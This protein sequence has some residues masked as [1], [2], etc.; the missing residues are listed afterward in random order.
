VRVLLAEDNEVNQQVTL[1]ILHSRGYQLDVVSNGREALAALERTAY[2]AVLMDCQMPEMDGY[3]AT[4]ELRRREGTARRTPVIAVTAHAHA[5]E[6]AKCLAAGMDDYVV[7][8][9]LP[10]DLHAALD[11]VLGQAAA[12]GQAATPG[13]PAPMAAPDAEGLAAQLGMLER[14]GGPDLVR[15]VVHTYLRDAPLRLAAMA[16]AVRAGSG[17]QAAFA[18]HALKG[19]SGSLGAARLQSLCSEIE[20]LARQ[21]DLDAVARKLPHIDAEFEVVR[22]VLEARLQPALAA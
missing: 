11:R 1:G 21:P 15:K 20:Q 2:A 16:D 5:S 18:A 12:P 19:S 10:A 17:E 22:Q 13:A 9:I 4:G 7:K 3:Q 8:P 14:A 6:R